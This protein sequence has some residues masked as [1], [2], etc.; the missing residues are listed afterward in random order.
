MLMFCEEEKMKEGG[1]WFLSKTMQFRNKLKIINALHKT[2]ASQD[3]LHFLGDPH[4]TFISWSSLL[5]IVIMR[6]P[7]VPEANSHI[8]ELDW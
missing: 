8:L 2:Q 7:S 5:L 4:K 1:G 6:E 3:T